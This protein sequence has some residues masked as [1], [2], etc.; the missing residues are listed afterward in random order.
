[1]KDAAS[2]LEVK[3]KHWLYLLILF[4]P[5]SSQL[6]SIF[7]KKSQ[8][9]RLIGPD[10]ASYLRRPAG[11]KQ[12]CE[13]LVE[14]KFLLLRNS[15]CQ[16]GRDKVFGPLPLS[17]PPHH[18]CTIGKQNTGDGFLSSLYFNL[19]HFPQLLDHLFKNFCISISSFS[20]FFSFLC[21]SCGRWSRWEGWW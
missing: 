20:F 19:I 1:M 18:L 2:W 4:S 21:T 8:I 5:T 15:Y 6:V 16:S 13:I 10:F 14:K 9:T 7:S 12:L 17:P 11:W 3:S